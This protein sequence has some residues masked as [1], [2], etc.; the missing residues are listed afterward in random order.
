[1]PQEKVQENS[2]QG[3]LALLE[4]VPEENA[5]SIFRGQN[6]FAA[7]MKMANTLAS[8]TLVPKAYQG[9]VQNCIVALEMSNRMGV[10]PLMVMQNLHIIQG[11]PSWGSPFI[12]GLINSCGRFTRL[13]FKFSGSGDDYGCIA[14]TN[15]KKTDELIEGPK[16]DWKM[17][18]AEFWL[19]KDG[20]K[21]KTMPE[22]MFQYRAASFFG[23]LHVPDLMFGMQSVEE[24]IDTLQTLENSDAVTME[25]IKG[26]M[27]LCKSEE[28]FDMLV[29]SYPELSDTKEFKKS[30]SYFKTINLKK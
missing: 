14:Y 9:N 2:K 30:I 6:S 15:D 12:I 20:S 22:L 11:K 16:V 29:D 5:L 24:V 13:Q 17:V 4:T 10:S 27:A 19:Q 21:W 28:E 18:K 7:G 25:K 26:Q 8:S 1:M 3:E 23:R